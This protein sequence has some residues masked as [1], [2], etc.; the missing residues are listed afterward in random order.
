MPRARRRRSPVALGLGAPSS[1]R[2]VPNS[3]PTAWDQLGRRPW[4][5]AHGDWAGTAVSKSGGRPFPFTL[6]PMAGREL[7]PRG[8]TGRSAAVRAGPGGPVVTTCNLAGVRCPGAGG[9]APFGGGVR[10]G[11]LFACELCPRAAP[12]HLVVHPHRGGTPAGRRAWARASAP[13]SLRCQTAAMP[14]RS[15][16]WPSLDRQRVSFSIS[17]ALAQIATD[18]NAAAAHERASCVLV[19]G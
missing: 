4:K 11:A 3:G 17:M 13:P 5:L 12:P 16:Q 14:N 7:P 18:L 19:N 1:S 8:T 6:C 10:A 9:R 15:A 2:S